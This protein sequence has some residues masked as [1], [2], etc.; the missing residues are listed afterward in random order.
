MAR[1]LAERMAA[2]AKQHAKTEEPL[3]QT[4]AQAEDSSASGL[5]ELGFT[6]EDLGFGS[7]WHRALRVDSLSRY[8]RI[9]FASLFDVD[10]NPV[11]R[12][13]KADVSQAAPTHLRFYDTETTGLGTAAGTFPFLHAVG[14][15]E[16][17]EWVVHQYF[18]A[19]YEQELSVLQTLAA[20]H[21]THESIVVSFNGR[22]FDW[23]LFETRMIMYR[24]PVLTISAHL[25]LLHPSRR[26]WKRM[27]GGASLGLIESGVLGV[28]RTDD[29]P[30]KEAPA[31]YFHYLD[32]PDAAPLAPVFDHNVA[33]V[34]AL[35]ALLVCL[36][37]TL[38]GQESASA[39]AYV[40]LAKWYD[41]WQE[42]E[43]AER[44]FVRAVDCPDATWRDYWLQSL[45]L[46][47]QR[48]MDEACAV[49]QSM[50]HRYPDSV[51]PLVELAKYAEHTQHDFARA[52]TLVT[53]ALKRRHHHHQLVREQPSEADIVQAQLLHRRTRIERKLDG[54]E[55]T[56][57]SAQ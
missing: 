41:E 26:L 3:V 19:A 23:P 55:R 21:F 28:E 40:A 54:L 9:Q 17:D 37:E 45:Y 22:T 48:R 49:W 32:Q 36:S 31:R 14:Q 6:E 10:L 4:A 7:V 20:Q 34:S 8:G 44:C 13:C 11:G 16:D 35:A 56:A 30:G 15:L 27:L 52:H 25:D 57:A 53:E 46:K 29:L 18:V 24:L 39:G 47:R 2:L 12:V 43:I 42:T 33:D 50:V 38:I 51:L 5:A 1:S